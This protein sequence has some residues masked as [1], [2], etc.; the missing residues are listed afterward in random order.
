MQRTRR[1]RSRT[2]DNLP[3]LVFETE[4]LIVVAATAALA[5]ADASDRAA[6]ARLLKA[7]VTAE[8]PVEVM[9][10]VQEHFAHQL[11]SGAAEPGWLSWYLLTRDAASRLVGVVG[12]YG[13]PTPESWTTV[14][15]GICPADEGRGYTTGVSPDDAEA[16]ESD[17]QGRGRLMVFE[18]VAARA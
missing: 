16:S 10:D 11:E 12:H 15:Y 2:E 14:G 9:R 8:W 5:R 13:A 4:R 18:R 1:R 17:R 7:D 3:G 6:F